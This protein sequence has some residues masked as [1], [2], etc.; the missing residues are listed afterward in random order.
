MNKKFFVA[1]LALVALV[2]TNA[3]RVNAQSCPNHETFGVRP[4]HPV[5]RNLQSQ[6]EVTYLN[7]ADPNAFISERA[8]ISRSASYISLDTSRFVAKLGALEKD[9]LASIK[10]QQSAASFLGELAEMN[11]ERATRAGAINASLTSNDLSSLDR[12][13]EISVYKGSAN[14]GDYYRVSLLSWFVDATAKGSQR[15]VDYDAV[16]LLKPGQTALFK[17]SSDYE[18]KR[19]GAAGRNYIAVTMR[20]VNSVGLASLGA[21]RTSVASR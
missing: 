2:A 17:L 14:E 1:V 13:T 15:V 3:H 7:T 4:L 8:G 11:L 10:K 16:V 20:S 12:K 19:S 5:D 6:I 21:S 9:G 18:T